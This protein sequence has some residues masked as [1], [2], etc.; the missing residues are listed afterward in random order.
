MATQIQVRRDT[1]ANWTSANP[2]LATG[3]IGFETDQNQ[4]KIGDGSTDYANLS[5]AGGSDIGNALT[6]VN[7]I[8]TETGT[9]LTIAS[10]GAT[11]QFD[12]DASQHTVLDKNADNNPRV[13]TGFVIEEN[14]AFAS[15]GSGPSTPVG[16]DY[17]EGPVVQCLQQDF[18]IGQISGFNNGAKGMYLY[19]AQGGGNNVLF[20]NPAN[21]NLQFGSVG[22]PFDGTYG[23]TPDEYN[24]ANASV[25]AI[26]FVGYNSNAYVTAWSSTEL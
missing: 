9:S 25:L 21:T 14:R 23:G 5:Y 10:D 1:A 7:S 13:T 12:V 15:G 22:S 8:S 4:F 26:E 6:D 24:P 20:Y 18:L 19:E 2:T 11:M 17:T 16:H 3:E